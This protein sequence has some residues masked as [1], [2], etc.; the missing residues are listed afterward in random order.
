MPL[1][2]GIPCFSSALRTPALALTFALLALPCL[3]Q[4]PK[5]PAPHRSVPPKA[6]KPIPLPAAVPGSIVVGPWMV[7][8]NFKSTI[9][10]NNL[11]QTSAVSV[12]PVLYLSNGTKFTL[13]PIQLAPAGI[14]VIDVNAALQNLGIAPYATLNGYVELQYSWPWDPICATVRNLDAVHSLIFDYGARSTKSLQFANQPPLPPGPRPIT[15]EG[16]WWKQEP[17]VTGFV[18]LSNTTVR[19][20]AAR[21]DLSDS[22]GSDFVYDT[23]T[24]SPHGTKLIEL[25]ELLSAPTS[26]GGIR[27]SYVGSENDLIISG[28]LQDQTNGYSASLHLA[29]AVAL[30]PATSASVAELGLMS[31]PADPMLAFPAGTVFT[32]YSVLRNASS[33]PL[34]A[35][36]TFWWMAGGTAHSAQLPALTLHASETRMLDVPAMLT[37]AGLKNFS[38][39]GSPVFGVQGDPAGL[40]MAGGSVDQKYTYVFGVVPRGV[41]VSS[42]KNLS[43]WSIGNGDDTMVTLWNA[44]DEAQDLIFRLMFEGGHYDFP[45]HLGPRATHMFNV[46]EIVRRQLPDVEGN[47]IP[48]GITEGSAELMGAQGEVD[49]ILVAMDAGIYNVRKATCGTYSCETCNGVTG[50]SMNPASF[51]IAVGGTKQLDFI[52]YWNTGQQYHGGDWTSYNTSVATVTSSGFVTGV[53]PGSANIHAQ[54]HFTE[55]TYTPNFCGY[56]LPSCPMQSTVPGDQSSGTVVDSTPVIT[57][58]APSLW[59]AGA[60][61]QVTFTGQYFGTNAPTLSFSP[62]AGIS[63][64]LLSY[65]DTQI[66]TSVTVATGTPNE[67]VSVSVKNNGYGGNAFNGGTVG[68]SATSVPV[69]ATV[70]SPANS[71]EITVIAWVNGQ[72]PDLQTLSGGNQF[73]VS[74]LNSTSAT[75]AVEVGAWVAGIAVD[76]LVQSDRDY[77]NAWL[78][79]YSANSAPPTTI[80]PLDQLNAGNFRLFNDSGH[81][82]GDLRVGKTPDPCSIKFPPLAVV[83]DWISTGETS[84]FMGASNTLSSGKFYQLA[85]GRVGSAGQAGSETINGRTVGWIWSVIEFDSQLNPTYSDH[86]IFPTYSI[87]LDGS[88]VATYPQSSVATFVLKD[89]TYLRKPSDIQ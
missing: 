36:P 44:A 83:V 18:T 22:Q 32:P 70:H 11:V 73:L 26:A 85:E 66:V 57:G 59:N 45:I 21:L 38:G 80:V 53:T 71:P 78:V 56:N 68:E 30:P 58:I 42:A 63:Y 25:N 33:A 34:V 64:S 46:S 27:I 49:S 8:A 81:G 86:A 9:Y 72:A 87:Y 67:E 19:T 75:C 6:E 61:K 41:K 37:A 47:V 48:S 69:F 79:K 54:D 77:A 60:T 50:T 84:P 1:T 35:T 5:V 7:D 74:H 23:V 3:A 39:S 51:T 2:S 17:N 62:A 65:N 55:P 76:L 43:Y 4:Q 16:M 40:L 88:L 12:T 52:E 20:I 24:I 14:S 31:G 89:D 10:L 13:S 82:S 29:A 28:G 15:A